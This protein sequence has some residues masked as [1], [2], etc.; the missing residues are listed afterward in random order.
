MAVGIDGVA[1][2]ESALRAASKT[3][4]YNICQLHDMV[5]GDAGEA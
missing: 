4:R 5:R 3:I 2:Q 1:S